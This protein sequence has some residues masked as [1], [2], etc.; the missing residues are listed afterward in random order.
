M[1]SP[2]PMEPPGLLILTLDL[3]T[4]DR[5][6]N[7]LQI[8]VR[9]WRSLGSRSRLAI[10]AQR[11]LKFWRKSCWLLRWSLFVSR[12][13][14]P[15]A[16]LRPLLRRCVTG[17][18]KAHPVSDHD[19]GCSVVEARASALALLVARVLADHH[20]AAVATDHLALV[21]DLLDAR[22]HLHCCSPSCYL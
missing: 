15:R 11:T 19:V 18:A 12:P 2:S 16:G 22:I 1:A 17:S 6:K 21:A 3:L 13:R 9:S 20:D 4:K 10:Y 8:H 14:P 5:L 7:G